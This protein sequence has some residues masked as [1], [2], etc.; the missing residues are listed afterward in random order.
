MEAFAPDGSA[1]SVT[2]SEQAGG[3][4]VPGAQHRIR[5]TD[6]GWIVLEFSQAGGRAWG[7]PSFRVCK[8]GRD[9]VLEV[10]LFGSG[11][12]LPAKAL[13]GRHIR[14]SVTLGLD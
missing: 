12:P 10:N 7:L 6:G 9:R 8:I 11:V 1:S 14:F 4:L 2:V 5:R 13:Q 3:V